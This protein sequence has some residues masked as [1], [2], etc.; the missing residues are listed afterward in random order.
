[1]LNSALWST[2][3]FLALFFFAAGAPKV[4]GRGLDRW[5]GFSELPRPL[6][7]F[8]GITE[9]LGSAGLVLPLATGV[10][11]WLTPLAAIGL[12][13]TVLMATGFHL[14]AGEQLQALETGFWSALAGLVAIGRWHLVSSEIRLPPSILLAALGV[15][16]PSV[17]VSIII[18]LRRPAAKSVP[19]GA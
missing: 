14:R 18:L 12:A 15:L 1:M 9:I 8:I 10:Q 13:V 2:Q 3:L 6:V 16:V 4:L 19:R 7:R 5:T 17:I 11:P